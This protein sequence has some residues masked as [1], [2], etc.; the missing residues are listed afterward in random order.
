MRTIWRY[1]SSY[2][3]LATVFLLGLFIEVAYAVAAPLS[4][5][6]LVDLAFTPRDVQVFFI[7]LGILVMGGSLS[8]AASWEAIMR[9]PS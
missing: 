1:F 4:L 2:K 7:I 6:Y 5:Q 8:I 9:F 3:T